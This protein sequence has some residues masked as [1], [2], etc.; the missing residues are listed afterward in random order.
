M[1]GSSGEGGEIE[2]PAIIPPLEKI[3]AIN[4]MPQK[5]PDK[6][7]MVQIEFV[8]GIPVAVNGKQMKL[9]DAIM[10]LNKIGAKHAIGTN[11][12]IEDRIIGMKIRDVYEAPAAEIIITAHEKLEH[13]VCTKT[14]NEFK[15]T[16]DQKWGYMCYDAFWYD[17]LMSDLNAFIDNVNQKVTGTV[18]VELYKG[19]AR[20]MALDTPNTIFEEKLATFMVSEGLNQ[21]ASAGFIEHYS[22]AMKLAQR[23]QRTALLAIGG[24]EK[25]LKLLPEMKTLNQLGY[26]IYATYKTHKFLR[27]HG[28]EAILVH[29]M[30]EPNMHP[31]LGDMLDANRFDIIINVPTK[32][33]R[34][35]TVEK[36]KTD[37]QVMRH[38]AVA[39]DTPLITT[40]SVAKDVIAK[41]SKTRV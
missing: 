22:L 40:V 26:Q 41:L 12:H 21:N 6:P 1:W 39:T 24:R 36:E 31:N 25:K 17:P 29:K 30:S 37:G 15:A 16:I 35:E 11:L 10:Q 8:K 2:D 9:A 23:R 27:S 5:A 38:K 3:L 33:D 18:T 19:V 13:Y 34:K 7:E 32:T 4:N 28:I 14:E 20:V